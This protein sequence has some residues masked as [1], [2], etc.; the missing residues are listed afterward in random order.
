MDTEYKTIIKELHSAMKK[1]PFRLS[2]EIS[3]AIDVK[4]TDV[5]NELTAI[6]ETRLERSISKSIKKE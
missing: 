3:N 4:F 5:Q 2:E 1:L 6:I